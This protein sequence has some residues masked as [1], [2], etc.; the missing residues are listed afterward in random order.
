MRISH[1]A[2]YLALAVASTTHA[3]SVPNADAVDVR[4]ARAVSTVSD[5]FSPEHALE[6]R[7]GGGGKGG[8]GSGGG[9]G[10]KSG[11]SSGSSG[12]SG[13]TSS[14]SNVGG[15]TRL[16]SGPSRGYGGG[17]YYGGGAAQP[18]KAGSKTPKGL[19]AGALIAPVL[20]LGLLPGIWLYSVWPYHFNNPYRFV[21]ESLHNSTNPNGT[22]TSLPVLCLC[23]DFSACGCDENDNQQY[24]KDLVGNGSY[25]ALNRSVINV[26]DV[27]GTTTLILNGTLPNGTTAPGGVDDAGMMLS[28]GKYSGYYAMALSVLYFCMFA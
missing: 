17:G 15:Q 9:G 25:D 14:T 28:V 7:K 26:A 20:L 27:N 1:L 16:G 23:Q 6:K 18:Y 4:D 13:R 5:I 2:T 10:G 12:S 21:N 8:G 24:L 19:I 11:S 3:V 22:N